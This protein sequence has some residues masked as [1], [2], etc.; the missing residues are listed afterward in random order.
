MA[1]QVFW[2][3][4]HRVLYIQLAGEI[5]IDDFR[6]S[7]VEIGDAITEAYEQSLGNMVIGI[8]DLQQANLGR[9]L[10]L[11][12][13]TAVKTIADAIDPRCWQAKPGFTVLITSSQSARMITSLVIRMTSQPLTTVATLGE[14]LTV[15]S[16]MY[17]ELQEQ[18]D[19]FK[20]TE[21]YQKT[22]ENPLG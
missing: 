21:F 20:A 19:T 14:S 9:F 10:R 13:T 2:V 18:L 15:V 22:T 8:V 3:I 11:A 6:Y 17:P 7:S 1:Y 5:T 4:Q 16:Y 12:M